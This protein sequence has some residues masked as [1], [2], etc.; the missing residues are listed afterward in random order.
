[1][2]PLIEASMNG[3]EK[4]VRTLLKDG[5]DVNAKDQLGDTALIESIVEW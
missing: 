2:S 1:M 5:A 4:S 3:H